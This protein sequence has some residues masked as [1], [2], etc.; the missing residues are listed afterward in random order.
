MPHGRRLCKRTSLHGDLRTSLQRFERHIFAIGA[1]L[2]RGVGKVPVATEPS[3]RIGVR[4]S[5]KSKELLFAGSLGLMKVNPR[6]VVASEH[7]VH[8]HHMKV[9]VEVEATAEPLHEHNGPALGSHMPSSSRSPLNHP[10]DGLH[11]QTCECSQ[12]RG[13]QCCQHAKLVGKREHVLPKGH[14]GQHAVDKMCPGVGHASPGAA[15]AYASVFAREWHEQVMATVVAMRAHEAVREHAAAKVGT[16]LSLHVGRKWLVVR[17]RR[18]TKERRKVPL[19]QAVEPCL[20]W[21]SRRVCR[22]EGSHEY[23]A[24]NPMPR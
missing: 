24:A 1:S 21:P 22:R 15:W 17:F 7:A 5:R 10:E 9:H 14:I 4:L 19:H 11:E 13:F 20:R 6:A 12:Y 18:V 2:W 3:Q 23:R 8:E 16:K